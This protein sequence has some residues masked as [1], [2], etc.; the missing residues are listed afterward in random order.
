MGIFVQSD[1][2]LKNKTLRTLLGFVK[3]RI[4]ITL[5]H[6]IEIPEPVWPFIKSYTLWTQLPEQI[7]SFDFENGFLFG[8]LG[9][10]ELG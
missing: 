2:G 7:M 10:V 5:I 6:E 8:I 1:I 3:T 4:L 9:M